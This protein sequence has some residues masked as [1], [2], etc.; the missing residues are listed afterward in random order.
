MR[1]GYNWQSSRR[2][3]HVLRGRKLQLCNVCGADGRGTRKV[4]YTTPRIQN[5][6]LDSLA[7]H[8][9]G[10]IAKAFKQ[11]EFFFHSSE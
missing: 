11:Q 3:D 1:P 10:K 4:T 6:I 9:Q 7:E 8:L 5:E 2:L